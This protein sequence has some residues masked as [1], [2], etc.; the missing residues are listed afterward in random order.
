MAAAKKAV[1]F[2]S[3]DR[4]AFDG[5]AEIVAAIA[6]ANVFVGELGAGTNFKYVANLLAFVHVTAAAEAMAFAA[7]CGLDQKLVASVISQS[8]GATSG[9]FNIRAALIAA[10]K[11]DSPLVTVAQTLEV[12]EQISAQAEEVGACTPLFNVVH[13]LYE[14]FA[15]RGEGN[16]DPGKLALYLQDRARANA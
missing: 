7:T 10:G 16:S 6:P 11:F 1:V 9:Q 2:A 15:A 5:V 3:G 13:D 14:Q 4:A 8:P 12:C